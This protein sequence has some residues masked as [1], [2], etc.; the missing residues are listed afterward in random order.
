MSIFCRGALQSAESFS[1]DRRNLSMATDMICLLP[2]RNISTTAETTFCG[3]TERPPCG[4]RENPVWPKKDLSVVGKKS[5]WT[6]D[7][8]RSNFGRTEL[9]Q[10]PSKANYGHKLLPKAN[11]SV[12]PDKS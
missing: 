11:F 9:L 2:Q 3:A 4:H 8:I 5:L 1:D 10:G 12:A 6:Y 7:E